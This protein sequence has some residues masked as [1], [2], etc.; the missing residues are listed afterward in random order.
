MGSRIR[1]TGTVVAFVVCAILLTVLALKIKDSPQTEGT[2]RWIF[3]G[4]SWLSSGDPPNCPSPLI[5]TTPVDL[6]LASSVLYPGQIRSGEYKPH[7]G[8]RFDDA[9]TSIS[10]KAPMNATVTRASRYLVNGEIQ[11]TIDFIAPCG[12]MFRFGHLRELTSKFARLV[13]ELPA[14]Y[15]GDQRAYEVTPTEVSVGEEI[16][17]IVGLLNTN[18]AFVDWGVY[19][20]RTTN[21][22]SKNSAWA[23]AHGRE[24]DQ[25]AVCWFDLLPPE[26]ARRVWE[27]PPSDS[28]SGKTSDYC[29]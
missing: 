6:N 18:N 29:R 23:S 26:D 24:L 4:Q 8:F 25:H 2:I 13:D 11:Y 12:I 5:L 10:V 17:T 27:L 22:E 20:L 21:A 16:A 19:D 1:A 15:E 9:G 14:P 7:G 3:N 28:V